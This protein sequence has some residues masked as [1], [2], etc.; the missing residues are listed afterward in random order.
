MN[1]ETVI[2]LW[3]IVYCVSG[4]FIPLIIIFG[5]LFN[6]FNIFNMILSLLGC[7]FQLLIFLGLRLR[8][9]QALFVYSTIGLTIIHF[10]LLIYLIYMSKTLTKHLRYDLERD[11]Q[12][13][14]TEFKYCLQIKICR[15]FSSNRS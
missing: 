1:D 13:N 2:R 8:N 12:T 5:F 3:K 10:N 14:Q 4:I 7:L 9:N 6:R 11:I 15:F